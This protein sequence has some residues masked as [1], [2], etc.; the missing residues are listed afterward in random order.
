MTAVF[1]MQT[2]NERRSWKDIIQALKESNS[3]PRLVYLAKLSFQ[4]EGEITTFHNIKE[5]I[6]TK[7][8]L[9]K[10]LEIYISKKKLG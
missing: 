7:P 3:Q 10:I 9:Q 8:A 6:T 2:L 1:S 4:T 5:F